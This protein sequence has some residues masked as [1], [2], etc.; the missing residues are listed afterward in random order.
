MRDIQSEKENIMG[1]IFNKKAAGEAFKAN[2]GV[3]EIYQTSD[4][5]CFTDENYA[6]GHSHNCEN[7][8]V[9][10][11]KRSE[12]TPSAPAK[13]EK[14]DADPETILGK[15]K[16]QWAG[17][18]VSDVESAVASIEDLEGLKA[19]QEAGW[20]NTKGGEQSIEDRIAALT[21]AE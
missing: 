17:T 19:L 14:T 16:T 18:K 9:I 8:E 3:D 15:T 6:K 4:G 2:K 20:V 13:K 11:V 10:K 5:Q 1:K 7:R 21:P 12:T